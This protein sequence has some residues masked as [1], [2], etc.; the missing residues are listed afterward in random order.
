MAK[1]SLF[2]QR[3]LRPVLFGIDLPAYLEEK[4]ITLLVWGVLSWK[5]PGKQHTGVL[6][7]RFRGQTNSSKTLTLHIPSAARQAIM[8]RRIF[9]EVF[10]I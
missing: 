5:A 2:S 10:V 3:L 4:D 8:L 6:N 7:A 9:T 1:N